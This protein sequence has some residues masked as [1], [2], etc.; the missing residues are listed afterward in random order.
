[1]NILFD[2][3]ALGYA[4][5]RPAFRAGISRAVEH[6]ALSLAR[7][8]ESGD[9]TLTFCAPA[10]VHEAFYY[11]RQDTRL[12]EMPFSYPV[13][14]RLRDTANR[15]SNAAIQASTGTQK[16]LWR[17]ARKANSLL[18]RLSGNLPCSID[19]GRLRDA[20]V[21][22]ST[23]IVAIPAEIRRRTG[24]RRFQTI[25]DIIPL[26][27]PE[28]FS[29]GGE[30]LLKGIIES[31]GPEDQI[32][33][34]SHATKNDLC[35]RCG[36]APERVIV[37]HLAADA[38]IFYPCGD[39]SRWKAVRH[40]YGLPDEPYVLSVA[41]LEPRKNLDH[42]IRCFSQVVREAPSTDV[43][44]VLAGAKGW[45]YEKIF[46]ASGADGALR[47][48]VTFT[49]RIE[50]EDLAALYSHASVFVYPSL[51]EGFGLPP[52]EAMQCGVPVITSNTSSLP[53]VVGEAGI[54]LAPDDADG[55][56]QA[57][58]NVSGSSATR[59]QM[60]AESLAQAA[61]F[62]WERCARETLEAYRSGN[63]R[64]D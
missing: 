62:S 33:A 2:T 23:G 49:G 14:Q 53:E 44:L 38:G 59:E 6:L 30:A 42:L 26:L 41:T 5:A 40:R 51:Y 12:R 8:C 19:R 7:V 43:R 55:L 39:M 52:L 46:A 1:M 32:I 20:D 56:C 35:D 50:D 31:L 60:R 25:Y 10:W 37:T 47:D 24:L 3:S 64:P 11:T 57:I 27:Q 29:W 58:I 61:K 54:M 17:V 15:T 63:E 45:D 48:R 13:F 9:A 21:Y 36:I 34:I 22:H 28:F 16:V 4:F 18:E